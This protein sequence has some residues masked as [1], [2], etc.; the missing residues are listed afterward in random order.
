MQ[1]PK[2]ETPVEPEGESSSH[3]DGANLIDDYCVR[4]QLLLHVF[5]R[6]FFSLRWLL[7]QVKKAWVWSIT[8]RMKR[9]T[10][11]SG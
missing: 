3:V 11:P 6:L 5:L 2:L 10:I 8:A 4:S 1:I 7:F 9:E